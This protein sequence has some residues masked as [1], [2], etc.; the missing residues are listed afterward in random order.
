MAE[1]RHLAAKHRSVGRRVGGPSFFRWVA[2]SQRHSGRRV[3]A[4]RTYL[5]SALRYGSAGDLARGVGVLL[6]ER[7]MALGQRPTRTVVA[8]TRS[9]RDCP[10][11]KMPA[12]RTSLS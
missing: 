11:T 7:A 5:Q 8:V 9:A 2:A 6:G 10:V 12:A 3:Q 1:F 4:A